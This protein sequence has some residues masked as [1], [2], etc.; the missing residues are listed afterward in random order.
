MEQNGSALVEEAAARLGLERPPEL[1]RRHAEEALSRRELPA[2]EP[3]LIA[4]Y[5]EQ[6]GMD[7]AMKRH[8][9]AASE[10]IRADRA[11]SAAARLVRHLLFVLPYET[12]LSSADLPLPIS[13]RRDDP[14][15]LFYAPIFLAEAPKLQ[16]YYSERGIPQAFCTDLLSDIER[17]IAEHRLRN[18]EWGL[19][20]VIWLRRHFHGRIFA[21]GRLQFELD[22]FAWPFAAYRRGDG[23]GATVVV[24]GKQQ[25]RDDGQFAD[26]DQSSTFPPRATGEAASFVTTFH[27]DG[28]TIVAHRVG[29]D[30][31]VAPQ[32]IHLS[33]AIWE[34]VLKPGDPTLAVHIPA[35]APLDPAA[36]ASSFT[37]AAEFFTRYL[38]DYLYRAFTCDSWM[39]DPQ[40]EHCLKPS[41]NLLRF[42][43]LFRLVPMQGADDHQHLE[44]VFVK[45][46]KRI[47]DAPQE[48][49]L[50]QAMVRQITAGGGFRLTGGLILPDEIPAGAAATA[51]G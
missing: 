46:V 30:G 26:A 49:S 35:G 43:R 37:G 31:V 48:S 32:P 47:E 45:P 3:R 27:D 24:A 39:L 8:V 33:A 15:R 2:S 23:E 29:D 7:A 28:E 25:F 18:G 36:V 4:R 38:P 19:S 17:W 11:L 9:S 44:R 13:T 50:Q 1:W 34:T 42:Q 41:S 21:V 12:P 20:E 5:A 10:A 16:A 14:A 40:L 22:S 51:D 6:L